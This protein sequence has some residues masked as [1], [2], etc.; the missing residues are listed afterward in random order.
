MEGGAYVARV[1]DSSAAWFNP[2]G[3]SREAGAQVSASAGVFKWIGV[4]PAHLPHSGGSVQ[5]VPNFVGG[6]FHLLGALTAGA[7][8][9][10][11]NSWLQE[12]DSE[13]I[14]PVQDGA[15]RKS[16]FEVTRQ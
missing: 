13:L 1:S 2:A 3:L 9:L 7:V 8:F 10:T 5:N 16:T 6:T 12:I 14:T 4:S 11:T 15:K